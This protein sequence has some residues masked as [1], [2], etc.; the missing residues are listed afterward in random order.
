MRI[1][2][3]NGIVTEVTGRGYGR[4]FVAEDV[5]SIVER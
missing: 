2:E 5:L 4:I 3:D 1:L